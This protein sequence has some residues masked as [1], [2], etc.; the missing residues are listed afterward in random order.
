MRTE[1][2]AGVIAA[3]IL[4]NPPSHSVVS[5]EEGGKVNN[6]LYLQRSSKIAPLE[7]ERNTVTM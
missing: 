5:K 2:L 4:V 1:G 6:C 3:S 7:P